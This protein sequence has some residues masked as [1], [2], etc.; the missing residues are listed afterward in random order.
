[1]HYTLSLIDNKTCQGE[2][3]CN[4]MDIEVLF[5]QWYF[6]MQLKANVMNDNVIKCS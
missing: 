3:V 1:M 4:S 5:L 6:I 2:F